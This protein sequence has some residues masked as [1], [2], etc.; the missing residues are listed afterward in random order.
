[1]TEPILEIDKL[2][3]S[4]NENQIIKNFDLKLF[5]KKITALIGQSGSGKSSIA[6]AIMNL[7]K[8]SQISGKIIYNNKINLLD[9]NEDEICKIRGNEIS[10]IFQDPNTSLNPLHKIGKQISEIIKIHQPEISISNIKIRINELLEMVDLKDFESRLSDY[11]HQLS[12][13]Q[14]QRIMIAIA[15]ANN[16]KILIADEPTTALDI[17][18]QKEILKILTK[19][20]NN[21]NLS[22]LLI[23]HNLNIVEEIADNKLHIGPKYQSQIPQKDHLKVKNN[24]IILKVSNLN[25]IYKKFYA[26][27]NINFSLRERENVGII[28][29]SGSGK[30]TLALALANLC[31]FKGD[32]NF[33]SNQNWQI[34]KN[35]LRKKIQIVFQDPFSSLSPRLKI[36][37]IVAEGIKI[38]K[39]ADNKTQHQLVDEVLKKMSLEI[40]IKNF[41]PHQLSGGQRQRIAIARSLILKPKI[42]ILDEPTSA[43]DFKTQNEILEHLID[44]QKTE[45]ITYITISHD[46]E[47]VNSISD[48][49]FFIKNSELAEIDKSKLFNYF[50]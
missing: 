4:F 27:R 28:G 24:K 41:Y 7:L 19:L 37:D 38:H 47:V 23:T 49:V 36:F 18:A 13:G 30:S 31:K 9:L 39:I 48:R 6:L 46:L 44:I 3:I 25:V 10:M 35:E 45:D 29:R 17:E 2:S 5:P 42:L 40:G 16:P 12:G 14:K 22:I 34:N 15:L 43:L 32:I 11:P 26:N 8:K 20:K 21:L 33:F 50:K 1:M